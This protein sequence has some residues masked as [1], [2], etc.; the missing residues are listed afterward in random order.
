[1]KRVAVAFD[2]DH[3]LAIDNKLERVAFLRLLARV[4]D[5]GG[6]PL[7]RWPT[8]RSTWTSS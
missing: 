8:K 3:T 7:E 1:L 5:E 4:V 6:A 2:V